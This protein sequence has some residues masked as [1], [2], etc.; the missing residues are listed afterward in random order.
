VAKEFI[1]YCDESDKKGTYFSNFY[2]GA[3]VCSKDLSL[4]EDTIKA[5]K[6]ELNFHQEV[7]WSKVTA[8]Y[9]DKYIKLI[10]CFFDFIKQNKVKI[11]IMFT[12]NIYIANNLSDYH[13]EHE[14]FILYYQFVKCAFGLRYSNDTAGTINVR[15]YFDK[16]PI[17]T[18]EKVENFKSYIYGISK[19]PPLRNV[20]VLIPKNQIAEV[21][22]KQ[23]VIL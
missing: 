10:D 17:N 16:L 20:Q 15:I 21:D 5:K 22:S 8:V 1:I 3:L 9:C 13:K 11:R 19:T 7:K 18:L 4:I 6:L 23:H 14:Y 12:Q 2:G